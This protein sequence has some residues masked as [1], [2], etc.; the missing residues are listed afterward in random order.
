MN[1]HELT[2]DGLVRQDG[3]VTDE[4]PQL[5]LGPLA[6]QLLSVLSE[7]D[8]QA[9]RQFVRVGQVPAATY[10]TGRLPIQ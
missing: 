6:P 5:D 4:I 1:T 7:Q 10:L 2:S 8:E 9:A 3:R